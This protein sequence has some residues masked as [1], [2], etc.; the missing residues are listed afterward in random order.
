MQNELQM[1][2]HRR[3]HCLVRE[4]NAESRQLDQTW[5]MDARRRVKGNES[6]GG[7]VGSSVNLEDVKDLAIE[8]RVAQARLKITIVSEC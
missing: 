4:R 8:Q 3:R 6:P 7:A 1:Q 2:S 5:M